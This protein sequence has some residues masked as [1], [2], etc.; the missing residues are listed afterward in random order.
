MP[1]LPAAKGDTAHFVVT[2]KVLV[3]D[4]SPFAATITSIGNGRG[5]S[6]A[7]GFEPIVLRTM[8]PARDG[9]RDRI[10]AAAAH[11][12]GNHLWGNGAFDGADVEVLRI[13]DGAFRSV[14]RDRV[15]PGGFHALGW[16]SVLDPVKMLAPEATRLTVPWAKELKRGMEWHFRIRAIDRHGRLSAPSPSVALK[17]PPAPMPDLPN[18]NPALI[19][20][21]DMWEETRNLPG[22]ETL[23][24][25]KTDAGKRVLEWSSVPGAAGY[26]VFRA[27]LPP[28]RMQPRSIRLRNKGERIRPGDLVI[29]RQRLF[30]ADR[31]DLVAPGNW[32][33]QEAARQFLPGGVQVWSDAVGGGD[34][35]LL[36]HLPDTPV[37]E[38]G[39]TY[40]RVTLKEG[41]AFTIGR[42][43]HS[44]T[45]Q[46]WYGVLDPA[47]DYR[48][49]VWMRGR[50]T[51]PA[52][53]RVTGPLG[54][55]QP[56]GLKPIRFSVTPEWKRYS[57][58]FRPP[59]LVT[60]DAVGRMNL[61]LSGPGEF[62]VDNFR[63]YRDDTA[64]MAVLP[65]NAD[66]LKASAMAALRT[67]GL[68]K[69][70]HRTYDIGSLVAPAGA[71]S[72]L[73][74]TTLPQL[75]AAIEHVGAQPWLQIEPHLSREEW[76][77]LAEYL[78]A[79]YDAQSDDPADMPWAAAR[80]ARGES[81]PVDRFR[82][83][84]FELGNETWNRIFAPWVFPAMNDASTGRQY[85]PGEVYGLYQ[86]HVLSILRDSPHWTDL[87]ARMVPVLGGWSLNDFG[88]LA[89]EHSPGSRYMTITSYIGGWDEGE[90]PVAPTPLGFSAIMANVL[91]TTI[92]R[93][94]ALVKDLAD[95]SRMRDTPIHAGTYE[96]GP[97]YVLSRANWGRLG[98]LE[99]DAQDRAM[100]SAAAGAATLDTFLANARAGFRLQSF[101]TFGRGRTWASHARWYQGGQ[102]YPAWDWLAQFNRSGTGDMLEVKTVDVPRTDIP[103]RKY[104]EAI[105]NGPLLAVYATRNDDR[106]TLVVISRK[107]PDASAPGDK[108]TTDVTI[109]LPFEK[110][111][112][113]AFYRMSGQFDSQNAAGQQARIEKID[114]TVPDTLPYL[115][116]PNMPGATAHMYVFEGLS[117]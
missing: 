83:I 109:E 64:Y 4:I 6:G 18:S 46:S 94:E 9:T 84:L 11:L 69:T 44:G 85:R 5:L 81:R 96:A 36:P 28:D 35:H 59:R 54:A 117:P 52:E 41:E 73:N 53:F 22:P 2:D 66:A 23:R 60:E 103:R 90:G 58:T 68:I 47:A 30:R 16:R 112:R 17:S 12:T 32:A 74:G 50:T 63:I 15:A 108:G 79:R 27:P 111:G 78:A 1:L 40:L 43:V 77:G 67:H 98:R 38:S 33:A 70:G 57:F 76:L 106:L 21:P 48:F 104:S 26:M 65:E 102:S 100:K 75:L 116:V 49:E 20:R 105:R 86:H 62:D 92:P 51:R 88:T 31:R 56:E 107:V 87:S 95:L 72:A 113:A 80:S 14:R 37:P 8:F 24:A 34:W 10:E 99:S 101:F 13:E 71:T 55:E 93:A 25:V 3:P 115:I 91:R 45:A 97:G 61:I 39:E 7:G 110:V 89:A 19:K 114:L 82:K 29:L 42:A